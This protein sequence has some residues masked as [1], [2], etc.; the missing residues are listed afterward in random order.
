MTGGFAS[1]KAGTMVEFE[2]LLEKDHLILLEF[3]NSVA[4]FDAQPVRIPVLGI[5][6]GYVPDVLI[7]FNPEVE[8]RSA[9]DPL[10]VEVK[11][12][13]DLKRNEKKYA[14]KFA[15]ASRFAAERGW[16][17]EIRDEALIRTPRLANLKFLREYRN[18]HPDPGQI[19]QVLDWIGNSQTSSTAILNGLARTDEAKLDSEIWT[20]G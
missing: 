7:Y 17:F 11:A 13:A 20:V 6:N 14:P 2:S 9:P 12:A 8:C 16:R 4:T 1:R 15:A 3:D 5:R 10:L 19:Q 18:V